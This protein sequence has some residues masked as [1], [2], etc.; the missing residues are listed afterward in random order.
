MPRFDFR[1]RKCQTTF[2]ESL[3]FGSK[4]L[5]K[6][7]ACGSKMTEKLIS[8]P[9]VHFKGSGWYKTDSRGS[10]GFKSETPPK[11]EKAK[12]KPEEAKKEA[13]PAETKKDAQPK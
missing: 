8:P 4:K 11:E 5:P 7:S 9:A 2:E 3:P 13:K 1:C 6:C 12:V 10:P